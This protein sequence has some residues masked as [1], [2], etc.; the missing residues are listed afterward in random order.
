MQSHKHWERTEY[1]QKLITHLFP[2]LYWNIQ[3]ASSHL[4]FC[5]ILAHTLLLTLAHVLSETSLMQQVA[6][7]LVARKW[8]GAT[9]V[10]GREPV[11]VKMSIHSK[12]QT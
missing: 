2:H 3:P 4:C 5:F 1:T 11:W 12:C 6:E 10:G 9:C 8:K 7:P